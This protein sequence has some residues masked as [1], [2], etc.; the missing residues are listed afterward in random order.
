L[1]RAGPAKGDSRYLAVDPHDLSRT[2]TFRLRTEGPD[3]GVGPSGV[4]H[5]RFRT[6]KEDLRDHPVTELTK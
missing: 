3:D 6:W 5:R 4:T 2:F 1:W